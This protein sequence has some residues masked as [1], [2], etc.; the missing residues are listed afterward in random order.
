MKELSFD[1]GENYFVMSDIHGQGKL[2][3]WV[4]NSLD[5]E[6]KKF[7]ITL[8]IDGDVIDRGPESIRILIDIMNRVKHKKVI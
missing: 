7:K 5:E 8:I 1:N 6:A 4:V 3:D 2:Y